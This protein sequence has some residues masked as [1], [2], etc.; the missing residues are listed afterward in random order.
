MSFLQLVDGR[1]IGAKVFKE[2]LENLIWIDCLFDLK[3]LE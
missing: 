1:T 3:L 2:R